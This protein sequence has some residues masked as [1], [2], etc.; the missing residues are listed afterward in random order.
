ML[1][2]GCNTLQRTAE[3]GVELS[4]PCVSIDGFIESAEVVQLFSLSDMVTGLLETECLSK[5]CMVLSTGGFKTQGPFE[6]LE[7]LIKLVFFEECPSAFFMHSSRTLSRQGKFG[8]KR[9]IEGV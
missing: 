7:R 8:L 2:E 5:G 3:A 9:Q 6:C 4:R 1:C